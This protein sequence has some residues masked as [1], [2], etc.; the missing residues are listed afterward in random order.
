MT[1]N[2]V[3][4]L[5]NLAKRFVRACGSCYETLRTVGM[6]EKSV[7]PGQVQP[8][9][10]PAGLKVKESME[11]TTPKALANLSPGLLQ[12]WDLSHAQN[13]NAESVGHRLSNYGQPTVPAEP[14]C[15]FHV[16]G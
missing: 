2:I 12:P 15:L 10:M 3:R 8:F 9:G 4:F 16:P 14:A 1:N 13:D 11:H 7:A 6:E 5:R